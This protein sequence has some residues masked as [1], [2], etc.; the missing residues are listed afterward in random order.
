MEQETLCEL[1]DCREWFD[2]GEYETDINS[3]EVDN[4]TRYIMYESKN[5]DIYNE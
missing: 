5:I 1:L 4:E 3:L 2:N